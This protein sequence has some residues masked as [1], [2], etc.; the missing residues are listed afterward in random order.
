MISTAALEAYEV[1]AND[2]TTKISQADAV[3][4][5]YELPRVHIVAPG[6]NVTA[7]AI[8][9]ALASAGLGGDDLSV[10]DVRHA[11]RF[12]LSLLPRHARRAAMN[13][14]Y[15]HLT[16]RQPKDELVGQYTQLIADLGLA[17]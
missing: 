3:R 9:E 7:N 5:H 16:Q 1:T 8:A 14:L 17:T 12:I 15:E 2:W 6:V 11:N 13:K 10:L 4:R